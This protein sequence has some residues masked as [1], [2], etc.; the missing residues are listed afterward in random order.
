MKAHEAAN[1]VDSFAE[2]LRKMK[3]VPEPK[4]QEVVLNSKADGV[5]NE[6]AAVG[7][8]VEEQGETITFDDY[9]KLMQRLEK[10][11]DFK[12]IQESNPAASIYE[13]RKQM[14]EMEKKIIMYEMNKSKIAKF[15]L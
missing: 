9:E 11:K 15:F 6:V 14:K 4:A 3:N 5:E 7:E 13:G 8:V 1:K 2:M 12:K 10:E